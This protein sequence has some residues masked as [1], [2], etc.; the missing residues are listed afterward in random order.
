MSFLNPLGAIFLATLPVILGLYILRLKRKEVTVSTTLFWRQVLED[1]E[2]N[3]P[4]QKLRYS[5]L[6]LVQLLIASLLVLALMNPAIVYPATAGLDTVF[7][8]DT[9]ASMAAEDGAPSRLETVKKELRKIIDDKGRRDRLAIVAAGADAEA[10]TDLTPDAS[11]LRAALDLLKPESVASSLPQA[12]DLALQLLAEARERDKGPRR[13]NQPEPPPPPPTAGQRPQA[14]V[15][16]FTDDP[17]SVGEPPTGAIPVRWAYQPVG[18]SDTQ[19]LAVLTAALT[20][21]DS[22]A[23]TMS[24]F[25]T[26]YLKGNGLAE[27]ELKV[28]QGTNLLDLRKLNLEAGKEES[29]VFDGVPLQPGR[30]RLD[31][32]LTGV[33]N[34]EGVITADGAE[35]HLE[36]DDQA[37]LV[38]EPAETFRILVLSNN[39]VYGVL[40]AQL[41]G[42]KVFQRSPAGGVPSE[43]FDLIV[44]D[45]DLP[46][47]APPANYLVIHSNNQELLPVAIVGE[48]ERPVISDWTATD[49]LLRFVNPQTF[50]LGKMNQVEVKE[51]GRAVL[52]T[53][54]GPAIVYGEQGRNRVVYWAFDPFTTDLPFKAT[55]PILLSAHVDFFKNRRAQQT[56]TTG[57]LIQVAATGGPVRVTRPDGSTQELSAAAG[58]ELTV[59]P[60]VLGF[61]KVEV[62]GAGGTAVHDYGVNLF[63]AGESILPAG[64]TFAGETGLAAFSQ[65]KRGIH[66]QWHWV[67]LAALLFLLGEWWIYHQRIF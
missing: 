47:N 51:W 23:G 59:R 50:R 29:H 39:Q 21:P 53:N 16:V 61:W 1:V 35:D 65:T 22:E 41:D 63:D 44:V 31:L 6:L 49:P 38:Y 43:D 27:A 14:Q 42:V 9:S 8:V 56:L 18:F 67:A 52:D 12:A 26:T 15:V 5:H 60:D 66:P 19:N 55:F 58:E 64:D 33:A 57:D 30:Y 48:V 20:N 11:Q 45:G 4:F 25:L 36:V 17:I 2:A 28:Y 37:F 54:Q 62:D 7:V 32:R 24:L 10:L 40:L 34:G 46:L 3:T 13:S